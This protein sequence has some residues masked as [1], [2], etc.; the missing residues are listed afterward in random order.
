M[1]GVEQLRGDL[2]VPRLDVDGNDLSLMIGLD[3]MPN[4]LLVYFRSATRVLLFAE[5][6]LN[7]HGFSPLREHQWLNANS[8]ELNRPH[9]MSP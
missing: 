6:G 9:R 3:F 5:F 4:M 2:E 8:V 7:G 1:R